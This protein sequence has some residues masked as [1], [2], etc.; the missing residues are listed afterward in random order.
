ML[1]VTLLA[2]NIR[3]AREQLCFTQ[4]EVARRLYVTPQTV[5]KWE[6]AI[7]VPD[8]ANLCRLAKVLGTTPNALLGIE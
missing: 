7:A 3:A 5:S 6:C 1:D 4:T 8:L 2:A